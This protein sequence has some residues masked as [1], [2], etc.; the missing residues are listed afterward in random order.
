MSFVYL[1]NKWAAA[2]PATRTL[3]IVLVVDL[4]LPEELMV[5]T[6]TLIETSKEKIDSLLAKPENYI[7]KETLRHAMMK[8]VGEKHEDMNELNLF[9]VPLLIVGSKY[10][11][12][13]VLASSH[14]LLIHVHCTCS[15]CICLQLRL[16]T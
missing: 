9:Q 12:F 10:D 7:L 15:Y 11:I 4:S 5:N 14:L 8:R 1:L 2:T 13:Q 3:S 16:C 6:D